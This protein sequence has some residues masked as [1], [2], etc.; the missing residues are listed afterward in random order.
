MRRPSYYAPAITQALERAHLDAD[1]R[2]VEAVMRDVYGTLD[3]LDRRRFGRAVREA[4]REL[5]LMSVPTRE[6]YAQSFGL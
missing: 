4:A 6:L 1:P 3:G 2:H 5:A